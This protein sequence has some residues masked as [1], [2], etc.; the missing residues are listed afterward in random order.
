MGSEGKWDSEPA[1]WTRVL[2]EKRINF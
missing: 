1:H 2:E